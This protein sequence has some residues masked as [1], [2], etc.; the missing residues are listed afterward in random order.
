[1]LTL[2]CGCLAGFGRGG[3]RAEPLRS[4]GDCRIQLV[5]DSQN[6]KAAEGVVVRVAGLVAYFGVWLLD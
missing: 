5:K 4:H 1:L 2:V 3:E 6:E